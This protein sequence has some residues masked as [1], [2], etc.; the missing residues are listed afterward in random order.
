MGAGIE[1]DGL[2]D[3]N[4]FS[5]S[6]NLHWDGV[7]VCIVGGALGFDGLLID[8]VAGRAVGLVVRRLCWGA[9]FDGTFV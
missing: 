7:D 3:C 2:Q 4:R 9:H 1:I 5:H 6:C 8:G